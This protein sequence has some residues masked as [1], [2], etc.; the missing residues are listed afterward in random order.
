MLWF[1]GQE[2]CGILASIPGIELTPPALE[3]E[4][5]AGSPPK[6]LC[7]HVFPTLGFGFSKNCQVTIFFWTSKTPRHLL[8]RR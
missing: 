4:V 5:L 2:A 8:L 3:G 1:F 7:V 6:C